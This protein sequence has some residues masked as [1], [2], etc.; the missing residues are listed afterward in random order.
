M[1]VRVHVHE[2]ASRHSHYIASE[3]ATRIHVAARVGCP[4]ICTR[5][6]LCGYIPYWYN[7]YGL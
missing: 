2:H 6:T 4:I 7:K 1:R 3:W 5:Y